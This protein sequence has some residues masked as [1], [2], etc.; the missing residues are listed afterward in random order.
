MPLPK[1]LVRRA[2]LEYI[3]AIAN[4]NRRA[5]HRLAVL[6]QY[7]HQVKRR[8]GQRYHLN[9]DLSDDEYL[10]QLATFN[11]NID[12]DALGDLLSRMRQRRVSERDLVQL[13]AEV[14]DWLEEA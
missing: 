4:L 9:P 1:E 10:V 14:A 5:G 2:S 12:V 3:T 8:L 13:A 6:G 11:P 7:Y